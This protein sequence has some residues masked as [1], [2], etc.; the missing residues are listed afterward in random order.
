[1]RQHGR[2]VQP[3]D[4]A[5]ATC[6]PFAYTDFKTAT[7]TRTNRLTTSR[8]GTSTRCI[9]R[10]SAL[11]DE[12]YDIRGNAQRRPPATMFMTSTRPHGNDVS[13]Y[14]NGATYT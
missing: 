3:G 10:S 12:D 11:N 1:M 8:P 4:P 13:P 6:S 7:Q 2:P 5:R 9:P 14:C